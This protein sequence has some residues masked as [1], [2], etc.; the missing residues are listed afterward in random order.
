MF[1][2]S[3]GDQIT[4][5]PFLESTPLLFPLL[6]IPQAWTLVLE[7]TFY[8]L[9]PFLVKLR[10]SV[11]IGIVIT[12]LV[13]KYVVAGAILNLEDPWTYRFFGFEIAF[14]LIGVLLFRYTSSRGASVDRVPRKLRAGIVFGGLAGIFL[15]APRLFGWA[16]GV[17]PF[18]AH[19]VVPL[20]LVV[21]I[22]ATIPS[23]FA[24]TK[25][26]KWDAKLGAY[27]YPIYL[28]H[29]LVVGG[30]QML[31]GKPW[32]TQNPVAIFG[33]LLVAVVAV[34]WPLVR[35]SVLV[36]ALRARVRTPTNSAVRAR[37]PEPDSVTRP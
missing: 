11:L 22:G 6:L 14:F 35:T 15:V 16:T 25:R 27:S 17:S 18:M 9:A 34:A 36:D 31:V 32:M 13:A 24:L 7:L 30:F 12:A 21:A 5:G 2:Q 8:L 37:E 20:V 23:L 28:S 33:L 4:V 10:S 1:L 19:Y 3:T 29:L 26:W